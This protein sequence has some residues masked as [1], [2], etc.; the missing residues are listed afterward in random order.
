MTEITLN[1]TSKLTEATKQSI[2]IQGIL[3]SQL[4]LRKESV[5][6]P[7][8]YSFL[9]LK[10]QSIDLPVIF[11][12]KEDAKLIKPNL[13]KSDQVELTGHYSTSPC[14]IRKSFTG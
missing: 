11:K 10:G 7:Y 2:T 8:Y 9:R 14:S 3:T 6:E 13:K 4:Q 5:L 12:Q 1:P